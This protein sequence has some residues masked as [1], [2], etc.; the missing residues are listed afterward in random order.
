M[1]SHLPFNL[2]ITLLCANLLT[3][4]DTTTGNADSK[5]LAVG[6]GVGGALLGQ[7]FK[8]PVVHGMSNSALFGLG[9]AGLGYVGGEAYN[10]GL[11]SKRG[12]NAQKQEQNK[13]GIMDT[14]R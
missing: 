4:C 7:A 12:Q 6:G 8:K 5:K 2:I 1:K 13:R 3:S 11:N 10:A 14:V 9:G